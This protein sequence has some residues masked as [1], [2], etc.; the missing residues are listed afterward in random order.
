MLCIKV[1]F[2]FRVPNN[3]NLVAKAT[4]HNEVQYVFSEVK[5]ILDHGCYPQSTDNDERPVMTP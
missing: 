5:S 3:Q 1:K 2:G 4:I